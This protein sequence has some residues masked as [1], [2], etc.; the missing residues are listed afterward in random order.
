MAS[1]IQLKTGTGSAVPSSLTQGEVAINVDNG[2]IYY[3]SGS[4]NSVKKLES[5]TNVTASGT[6]SASG[7]I[8]ALSMSGDGSNLT[9]VSATL[10]TGVIS[11]SAQLPS[12]IYSSSLQTLGNITSSGTISASGTI[13]TPTITATAGTVGGSNILTEASETD[14][15]NLTVGTALVADQAKT[16]RSTTNEEF[17]PVMVDSANATATAEAL[18]TPT[19][20]FTFNPSAKKLTVDNITNVNTSHVTASGNISS[21]GNISATGNL[22]IDGDADIDGTLEADAITV[23]GTALNTVIA[24]VTVNNATSA[25]FAVTSSHASTVATNYAYQYVHFI[26]NSDIATNW[27]IPATNG[28]NAHNWNTDAGGNGTTVGSSTISVTRSKQTGGF[29]VPFTGVLIGFTGIIRDNESS[30]VAS[31]P[32]ALGLFHAP[33]SDYGAKS[34]ATNFTLQAY[35]VGVTTGGGGS[36]IAGNC[37][38]ID[39]GR[40]LAVNQGDLIIPAVLEA[41]TD[42]VYYSFSM[43]IKTPIIE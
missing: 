39:T 11:S 12:G 38:V 2:L 19:T 41:T 40:S 22:D 32:G 34:T 16:Q 8:T 6:I 36:S 3:G 9:N 37:K 10:P 30:P 24:G 14:A 4:V 7:V 29:V 28:P 20:G 43:I 26:G 17:F 15:A 31:A 1:T 27:A 25:S 33:F 35:A 23:G 13:I 5:F 42:K 21:S 18:K